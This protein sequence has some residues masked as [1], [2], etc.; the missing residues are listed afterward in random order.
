MPSTARKYERN[1]PRGAGPRPPATKNPTQRPRPLFGAL[2]VQESSRQLNRVKP[3]GPFCAWWVY[4]PFNH[5]RKRGSTTKR[6]PTLKIQRLAWGLPL[7]HQ[8]QKWFRPSKCPFFLAHA[9]S[10]LQAPLCLLWA[11]AGSP[12]QANSLLFVW[13]VHLGSLK[14]EANRN[15]VPQ[16]LA[17]AWWVRGPA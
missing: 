8:F 9:G 15:R 3:P 13:W 10:H 17:F 6:A 2:W 7:K 14:M 12:P 1:T 11:H 5:K 16:N 4:L